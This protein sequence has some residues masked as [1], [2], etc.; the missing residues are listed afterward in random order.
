MA[1]RGE[2]PGIVR[3][4]LHWALV[5]GAAGFAAGFV[6]PMALDPEANI[7]P[8]VGI[9]VTGPGGAVAGAM[10]GAIAALLPISPRARSRALHALATVGV[11]A[12]LVA[13]LPEPAV[14]G[15]VIEATVESC[16]RPGARVDD[17]LA[18]WTDALK[19]V[20]W[21][22]PPANWRDV[23][24]RN[25]SDAPGVVL[26]MRIG[27]KLPILRHRRPW[28]KGETSAGPWIDADETHAYY[29]DSEGGD[30]RR[31]VARGKAIYWP[32]IDPNSENPQPAKEWPPTDALGFLQLQP[33]DPVPEGYRRF[34][35]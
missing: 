28:D 17:S 33:L 21:A 7:G 22:H 35:Q 29:D 27:R 30:C 2:P 5:L 6:G 26:T 9:L 18:T 4:A 13:L 34:V 19:R 8:I 11:L 25:A 20:T 23:A 16:E 1:A 12:I 24:A 31:Y 32:R 10:L 3:T 14:R 15:Y